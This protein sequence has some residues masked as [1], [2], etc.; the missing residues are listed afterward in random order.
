MDNTITFLSGLAYG[1]SST[2][3]GH[4]ADTVKT[5][6]QALH[7]SSS[8]P[9]PSSLQTI[10]TILST[11]GLR[12]LYKGAAPL[13]LMGGVI[14]S[15]QFGFYDTALRAQRSSSD[16]PSPRILGV[17]DPQVILAGFV[18]GLGRALAEAPADYIKT[19]RQV[20]RPWAVRGMLEGAGATFAR[21][22]FL[23][24]SFAIYT[25][26]SHLVVPGGLPPFLQGAVCAN[27]AWLT[28]WP[29]D[30]AKSQI[31]S[32]LFGGGGL[33]DALRH[34]WASG[35]LFRGLAPGLVRSTVANG[36]GMVV[37]TK[38]RAALEERLGK[39]RGSTF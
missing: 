18:G 4:P 9:A 3:V 23:F 19:R 31:Q 32:G 12:G 25:D 6:I 39:G 37:F 14:R 21:N 22:S 16:A 28:V 27:L 1:L 38:T 29:L 5:R 13:F 33:G 10:K 11:E 2:L 36:V 8:A 20:D 30:V 35:A 17:F 24:A 15:C 26:L 34:V 7:P